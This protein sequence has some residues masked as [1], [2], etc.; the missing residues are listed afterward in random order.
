MKF[1]LLPLVLQ[2][3][4]TKRGKRKGPGLPFSPNPAIITI[5]QTAWI[6]LLP[7]GKPKIN[8]FAFPSSKKVALWMLNSL[9]VLMFATFPSLFLPP[10]SFLLLFLLSLFLFFPQELHRFSLLSPFL[11]PTERLFCFS[12]D[13]LTD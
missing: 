10:L 6:P 3:L 8:S 13:G 1:L 7:K 2:K 4:Q 9:F 12:F 5:I 11:L